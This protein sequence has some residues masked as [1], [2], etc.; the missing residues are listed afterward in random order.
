MLVLKLS[1]AR[2]TLQSDV[3]TL[4]SQFNGH[5]WCGLY[6]CPLARYVTDQD[7]N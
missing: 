4:I 3:H 6:C 7:L 2:L 5:F 1:L